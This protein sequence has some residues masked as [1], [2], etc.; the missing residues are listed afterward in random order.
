[1]QVFLHVSNN[2]IQSSPLIEAWTET[3]MILRL[4]S[5]IATKISFMYSQKGNCAASVSVST[6][7]CLW[8]IY[9]SPGSVHSRVG[10]PILGIYKS[11][12]DT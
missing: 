6:L 1:M 5:H 4:T 3:V 12:T 8:A 10:R 11:L 7:M 2:L 9:I